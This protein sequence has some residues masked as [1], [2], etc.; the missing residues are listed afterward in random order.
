MVQKFLGCFVMLAS[1]VV[2]AHAHAQA[3]Y[4]RE[5][6]DIFQGV[7]T[8]PASI[9]ANGGA[10]I[11]VAEGAAG[12]TFN[13]ASVANRFAY[14]SNA[15]WDWDWNLD[16]T[17]LAPGD[18]SNTDFFN[19]GRTELG[20]DQLSNVNAALDLQLEGLGIGFALSTISIR[21]CEA[22]VDDCGELGGTA[23]TQTTVSNVRFG[24]GYAF[25]RGDLVAGINLLLPSIG[26]V[27]DEVDV[28]EADVRGAGAEVGL[29]WRPAGEDYRIGL[30]WK[31][32]I[33]AEVEI[34]SVDAAVVGGRLIPPSLISPWVLGIGAAYAFGT[35][36]MNI[37]PG[38]V[39][40]RETRGTDAD[41]EYEVYPRGHYQIAADVILVGIEKDAV[42]LDG[43]FAGESQPSGRDLGLGL[44][45]GA[46]GELWKNR[47][48]ARLGG[49]LE[50]SRV[51][52]T[53][54][55]PHL[56]GGLDF[57]LFRL[58]WMWRAGIAFDFARDFSQ[59]TLSGGFWH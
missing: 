10:V 57:R 9:L 18:L 34:D 2:A 52:E 22:E 49:Y 36:P 29:L 16:W 24:A 13:P 51:S 53:D 58:I 23:G 5:P 15:W 28:P 3:A 1:V 42:G 43:W 54:P 35:R 6:V 38:Y 46:E 14:G 19:S 27:S 48:I 55:R 30:T 31:P 11:G 4:D 17:I 59:L 39:N 56:T 8:A 32:R 7:V 20:L 44:H 26:F 21:E 33:R 45:V 12:M 47:M 41:D 25:F 50:P 40:V 37:E